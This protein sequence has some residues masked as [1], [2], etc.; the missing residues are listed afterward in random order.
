MIF[1]HQAEKFDT[2]TAGGAGDKYEVCVELK[3][4]KASEHH[5]TGSEWDAW[6][7]VKRLT[8]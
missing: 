7:C 8:S 6:G 5:K 1:G 4:G 3:P 2:R